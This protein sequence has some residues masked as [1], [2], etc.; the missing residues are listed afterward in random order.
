MYNK[1]LTYLAFY[2]YFT[3]I[4]ESKG[5]CNSP[6]FFLSIPLHPLPSSPF[7]SYRKKTAF[8]EISHFM[9]IFA[10]SFNAKP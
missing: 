10:K 7:L 9:L 5:F 6:L 1:N 8:L 3:Q 4:K 2:H